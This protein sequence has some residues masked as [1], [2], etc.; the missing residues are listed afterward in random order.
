MKKESML[1]LGAGIM[2]KNAILGAKNLGFNTVVIDSNPNAPFV[3]LADEFF[4]IDLKD[5]E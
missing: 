3:S 2:Q 5:R 4:P 1:I